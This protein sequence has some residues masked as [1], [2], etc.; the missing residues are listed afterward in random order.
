MRKQLL[1]GAG[2]V[3]IMATSVGCSSN[4]KPAIP[5]VNNDIFVNAN[6]T[7]NEADIDNVDSTTSLPSESQ[8]ETSSDAVIETTT[9]KVTPA[10]FSNS[11]KYDQEIRYT[12]TFNADK[13]IVASIAL[14]TSMNS[15]DCVI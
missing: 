11:T 3:I 7:E 1:I 13:V 6:T 10:T 14:G 15:S 9:S 5:N 4:E 8:K 2:L 12:I